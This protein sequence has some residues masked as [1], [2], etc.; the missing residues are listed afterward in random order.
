MS[1]IDRDLA[2]MFW[3]ATARRV[4]EATDLWLE[5]E[6][7]D[8]AAAASLRRLLH[9]WKGEAHMLGF[10]SVGG[11]LQAM[12]DVVKTGARAEAGDAFLNALDGI[13]TMAVSD[14]GEDVMP[15]HEMLDALREATSPAHAASH[16]P[17]THERAAPEQEIADAVHQR[18]SI[19]PS[20]IQPLVHEARRL[21]LE[22]GTLEPKIRELRRMLRA[23]LAE[24]DPQLS[25]QRLAEQIV[26]TL[27]YGADI[28]RRLAQLN[29]QWS[30][31]DFELGHALE[32]IDD[33]VRAAAVVSV[34]SLRTQV[35]R[36]ARS[37]AHAL[38][39]KVDV[40]ITGDA[41]VDASVEKLLA[42]A[43]LHLVRN[44]VD[45]G[46]EAADL[47]ALRGKPEAGRIDVTIQQSESSATVI[48]SDDGGGI[49]VAA[50]RARL[51]DDREEDV[52]L[53]RIFEHGVTTRESVTELSGRG[54]GLDVVAQSVASVG[55][56]LRVHTTREVGTRFELALPTSLRAELVVPFMV[57]GSRLA[58]PVRVIKV[59]ERL[60]EIVPSSDGNRF[61]YG[62]RGHA[63][64]IPLFDAATLFGAR[65]EPREGDPV[66]VIEHLRGTLALRVDSYDNPRALS[67]ERIEDLVVPSDVVRGAGAAPDGSVYFLLD[68]ESLY[69][70]LRGRTGPSSSRAT[71][72]ARAAAHVL[73]VEDAPVARELLLGI[74]RS[75]GLRVSDAAD[76]REGLARAR[77]D[78]PDLVL[79]DV[80]M[81]FLNGLE[82]I[83]EMRNDPTLREV[84]VLV[85][86][87]RTDAPIRDRARA[88]GVR[89]FLSKQKFVESELREMIDAC[90]VR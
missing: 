6:R 68:V 63:K 55:G 29:A 90:L 54:V 57:R 42:P 36:A 1:G 61:A 15:V 28:E 19:E 38:G 85:L 71:E 79:T 51:G 88:L 2:R 17:V 22:Q 4:G 81:P 21:H 13:A 58:L 11:L 7:G 5:C 65:D 30:A 80:E 60:R 32:R 26:K 47:R 31:V 52:V 14:L 67:F 12:E 45:H 39:R 44:A 82:M 9:T 72:T 43:L 41:Y 83:A 53:Q 70:K 66:L 8:E 16:G 56:S 46:I 75:L 49:D 73:V 25:P 78:V 33:V 40:H 27:G 87:T 48:V 77:A 86:T 69:G 3:E 23:L 76:G 37:A 34:A 20:M 84:P 10:A 18:T 62:A 24:I 64:L 50:L 35:L 74:L 89:G 59:V